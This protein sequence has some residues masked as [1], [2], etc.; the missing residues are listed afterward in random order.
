M[1]RYVHINL[2][3]R[4]LLLS[5]RRHPSGALR[6]LPSGETPPGRTATFAKRKV[7][8]ASHLSLIKIKG[9]GR[10]KPLPYMTFHLLRGHIGLYYRF[11]DVAIVVPYCNYLIKLVNTFCSASGRPICSLPRAMLFIKKLMLSASTRTVCKPSASCS[12][13]PFAPP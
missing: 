10:S 9:N 13:S 5:R 3:G 11:Q 7:A 12:A 2:K 1:Y 4:G 6:H 8:V